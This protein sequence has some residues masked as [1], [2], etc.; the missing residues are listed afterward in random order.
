[1]SSVLCWCTHR[2]VSWTHI[3]AQA[4]V[5]GS[6]GEGRVCGLWLWSCRGHSSRRVPH[7]SVTW[8]GSHPLGHK[9]SGMLRLLQSFPAVTLRSTEVCPNAFHLCRVCAPLR[10]YTSMHSP[11]KLLLGQGLKAQYASDCG[12]PIRDL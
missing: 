3:D 5:F 6:T 7:L 4:W 10:N 11:Q 8:P 2:S 9:I 12:S 1:M